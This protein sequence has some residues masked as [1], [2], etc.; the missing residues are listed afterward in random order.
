M[1]R[2][3][4]MSLAC[5][6]AMILASATAMAQTPGNG[7]TGNPGTND[8]AKIQ[9]DMMKHKTSAKMPYCSATRMHNCRHHSKSMTKSM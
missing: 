7:S 5:G 4:F 1:T 2:T 9:A 6:A 8:P 3:S